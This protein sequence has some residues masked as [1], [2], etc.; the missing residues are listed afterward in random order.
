MKQLSEIRQE[1]SQLM[2][3]A[4][5]LRQEK[6][7]AYRKR[8]YLMLIPGAGA[9]FCGFM[10]FAGAGA[11]YLI[12][13]IISILLIFGA[14]WV[15]AAKHLREFKKE[16]KSTV[17][18]QFVQL[19]YPQVA[20]IPE[21]A[22]SQ[23]DFKSSQLYNWANRY[24]GEDYFKGQ[25]GEADFQMSELTVRRRTRRS[26]SSS[27][28]SSTTSIFKGFF[29]VMDMSE[30]TYAETYILPDIAEKI[31]GGLGKMLQQTIGSL[32]SRGELVYFEEHPEFEK[33]YVVYST[34]EYS[35]RQLISNTMVE[36]I[37]ELN[38]RWN[39]RPRISFINNRIYI[40]MPTRRNLFKVNPHK[41]LLEEQQEILE[42]IYDEVGLCMSIVES[43]A[44]AY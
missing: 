24:Q 29:V 14:Y 12:G 3:Q 18:A 36:A 26:S 44:K 4:E 6:L 10:L 7:A 38:I 34:D 33:K 5:D 37:G 13:L 21:G 42:E 27:N 40:A 9:A 15:S 30:K 25:I 11:G 28:S 20:Y 32:F 41:S 17:I 2:R 16:F 35:A 31:P 43:I 23:E 1:I 39:I 22:I 19:M 8:L